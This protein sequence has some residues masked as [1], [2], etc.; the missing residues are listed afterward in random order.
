L[1]I[2]VR[3]HVKAITGALDNLTRPN[4]VAHSLSG[5]WASQAIEQFAGQVGWLV[6]LCAYV[7]LD[8]KSAA[9]VAPMDPDGEIHGAI[10]VNPELGTSTLRS[11]S[12]TKDILYGECDPSVANKALARLQPEPV[13]PGTEP[14]TVTESKFH[15]SKKAYIECLRDR[16][17]SIGY[18]RHMHTYTRFQKI[19]TM[20][21]GHSPFLSCPADLCVHLTGLADH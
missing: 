10:V 8:G 6:F 14:I 5:F 9:E 19:L 16:V 2:S 4:I 13:R 21:T 3:S 20:D 12:H 1:D 7:P 15:A 17:I 11:D 18:Q